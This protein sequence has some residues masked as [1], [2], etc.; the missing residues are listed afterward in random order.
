MTFL[1]VVVALLSMFQFAL[2]YFTCL[3]ITRVNARKLMTIR[4]HTLPYVGVPTKK[5]VL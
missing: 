5:G 1:V 2:G 3:L 4:D